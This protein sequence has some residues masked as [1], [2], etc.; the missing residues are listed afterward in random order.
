MKK[1]LPFYKKVLFALG[2]VVLLHIS[3][4]AIAGTAASVSSLAYRTTFI[5]SGGP[6]GIEELL[7]DEKEYVCG[8]QGAADPIR[9]CGF[10]DFLIEEMFKSF[11]FVPLM[12]TSF[13]LAVLTNPMQLLE[14]FFNLPFDSMLLLWF[15]VV[16]LIGYFSV[17]GRYWYKHVTDPMQEKWRTFLIQLAVIALLT[18]PLWAAAI[19]FVVGYGD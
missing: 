10:G 11:W 16:C 2:M 3:L 9:A 5:P 8:N 17:L 7:T 13:F 1:D 12:F 19:G 15:A 4:F 14:P 6:S 18:G